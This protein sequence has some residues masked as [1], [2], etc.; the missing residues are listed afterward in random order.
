[1]TQ[2]LVTVILTPRPPL[3]FEFCTNVYRVNELHNHMTKSCGVSYYNLSK[4]TEFPLKHPL[5]APLAEIPIKSTMYKSWAN[6]PLEK[7][8]EMVYENRMKVSD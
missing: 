4:N 7:I 3:P 1:M 5:P 8:R 2:K 6:K